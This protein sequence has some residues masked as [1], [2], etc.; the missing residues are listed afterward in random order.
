ML[1][2]APL[3]ILGTVQRHVVFVPSDVGLWEAIF[4]LAHPNL[5]ERRGDT[6]G[7]K[8][9]SKNKT[10][11]NNKVILECLPWMGRLHLRRS[12]FEQLRW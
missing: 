4:D 12:P 6:N 8:A 7:E 3:T 1:T 2:S 9:K 5:W 10:Y 11:N